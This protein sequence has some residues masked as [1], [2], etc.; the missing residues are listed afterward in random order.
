M[1]SSDF[2]IVS[3]LGDGAFS[4]VF[5][6][7]RKSDGQ[8]YAL[9]KVKLGALKQKEMDMSVTAGTAQSLK[10]SDDINEMLINSIKAKLSV[11]EKA[12]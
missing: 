1:S 9:K 7:M 3:K 11:L 8:S 2:E 5:K 4:S 6:V 10:Y 12:S